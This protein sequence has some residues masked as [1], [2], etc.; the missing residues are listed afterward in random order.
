MTQ[1]TDHDEQLLIDYVLGRCEAGQAQAVARRLQED[2][3]FRALHQD[4]RNTLAAMEL[5]PMLQ[6]P[7]GL[8][9]RVVNRLRQV[10]ATEALITRAEL[11]RRP[12]SRSVFSLREL[13]AVASVV[14]LVGLGFYLTVGRSA[15]SLRAR[16][17]ARMCEAR[18]AGIGRAAYAYAEENRGFL[19]VSASVAGP[20]LASPGREV[21]SNSTALFQLIRQGYAR[22]ETFQCP[23]AAGPSPV[24]FAVLAGMTDF[25]H[26][27][28][29]GYSYQHALGRGLSLNDPVLRAAAAEM[30]ILADSNPVFAGG[31]FHP[32][33]VATAVSDNHDGRGQNVLYLDNHVAWTVTATVGVRGNNIYLAEGVLEYRG[34][35]A[36]VSPTDTFLLPAYSRN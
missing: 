7:T 29:I 28:F 11:T 9:Q 4:I 13:V 22:A 24:G 5:V 3:S 15:R 19:P 27:T 25:P 2:A 34:D 16:Q 17:L 21:L 26:G 8:A 1:H 32:N 10:H 31:R 12:P 18:L 14:L 36:P 6:P 33:R 23:G 30:V 35:E 20:W